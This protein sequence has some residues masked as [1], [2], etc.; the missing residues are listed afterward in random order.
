MSSLA[1][2]ALAAA[3]LGSAGAGAGAASASARPDAPART[4]Y[5]YWESYDT[6]VPGAPRGVRP[7][8]SCYPPQ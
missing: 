2:L 5:F 7:V 4:C 3:L 6:G 8:V 1:R